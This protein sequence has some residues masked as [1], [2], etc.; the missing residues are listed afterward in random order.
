MKLRKALLLL[1]L[2][3]C[4]F[5]I[6]AQSVDQ[7]IENY[8]RFIGGKE[9]WKK[10]KTMV[11]SGEY[12]YGGIQFPFRS[13]AKAP[14]R[15]KF[16]VPQNR[17]EYVQGFDGT[18]GWKIDGFK[19]ETTLTLLAGKAA[20]AMANEAD[21]ELEDALIDYRDK[22]HQAILL[23]KDTV[24]G[25]TCFKVKIVRENGDTETYYFDDQ[26]F[27]LVKKEAVS[28]NVEMGG[29]LLDIFYSDYR[30]VN[31]IRIPFKTVHE[32]SGQM[33]L[34]ITI[35]KATINEPIEDKVFRPSSG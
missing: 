29:A 8:V 26:D 32:S 24:K 27:T 18:V 30:D 15:Y 35:A 23:G 17:K 20:M 3:S 33:I 13:Y 34:T 16:V 1:L 25:K 14:N 5:A 19:N 28:K 6:Q 10:V 12:N 7:V 9:R 22:G 21:V 4:S 11:A 2:L 31:G